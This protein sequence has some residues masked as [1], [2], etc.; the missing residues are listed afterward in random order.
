MPRILHVI[1]III[2]W[3]TFVIPASAQVGGMMYTAYNMW[4][5]DPGNM[6]TIN[7]KRG[8]MLPAGTMVKKI[9]LIRENSFPNHQYISFKS[10]NG[11]K[12]FKVY[13]RT[14]IHPGKTLQDYR[15]LMFSS[16]NFREQSAG[17]TEREINAILRGVLVTG[18]SR[19]AVIMSYG[20]P[21]QHQTPNLQSHTWRYWTSRM[22]TKDVCFG[23][24]G[25]T[26]K[27]NTEDQL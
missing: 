9:K 8:T 13:F 24:N 5:E 7:Y 16:V 15:K 18:M 25:K 6:S 26:V 17:M 21:P 22:V 19:K 11:N 3:G 2:L 23:Y 1:A 12:T 4:Y 14:K 27:C 20:I 10:I